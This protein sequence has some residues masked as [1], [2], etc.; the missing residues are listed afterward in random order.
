MKRNLRRI[1]IIF[2]CL[3]VGWTFGYLRLPYV[4]NKQ[5]YWIGFL[6]CLTIV[7]LIILLLQIWNQNKVLQRTIGKSDEVKSIAKTYRFNRNLILTLVI[8]AVAVGSIT[9]SIQKEKSKSEIDLMSQ[10]IENQGQVIDS[11]NGSNAGKLLSGIIEEIRQDV[12]SDSSRTISQYSTSWISEYS[13]SL[14]PYTYPEGD[15]LSTHPL[16]PERGLLLKALLYMDMNPNQLADIIANTTFEAAD[17]RGANLAGKVLSGIDLYRADLR[18]ANL[19]GATLYD[20]DLTK[21]NLKAANLNQSDLSEAVLVRANLNWCLMNDADLSFANF[22]GAELSNSQM[23]RAELSN[24]KIRWAN[25]TGALVNNADLQHCNI[26]TT[27]LTN[28]NFTGADLQEAILRKSIFQE[29]ILTDADLD[30][31]EVEAGW[32]DRLTK[33]KTVGV[34]KIQ[35]DYITTQS[36]TVKIPKYFLEK[37]N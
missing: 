21:A 6:A 13:F 18:N 11:L 9:F 14:K 7:G 37:S 20:A 3:F 32:L 30:N 28:S 17:L 10:I 8:I 24:A 2:L 36:G 31:A 4:E 16:S 26:F 1:L 22:D 5:A 33:W 23:M 15:S 12:N 35:S 29:T 19:K 34:E 27:N 25:M